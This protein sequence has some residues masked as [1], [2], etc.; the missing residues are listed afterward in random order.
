[1]IDENSFLKLIKEK[2]G[3]EVS[4]GFRKDVDHFI[5]GKDNKIW[6]FIQKGTNEDYYICTL[7]GTEKKD[8]HYTRKK[9]VLSCEAAPSGKTMEKILSEIAIGQKEIEESG[10]KPASVEVGGHRCSHYSFAFGERAYKIADEF[11][12]TIEY[13]NLNDEEGGFRLRNIFTGADVT[14]PAE[15]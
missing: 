4:L 3:F 8:V 11:G 13:S 5:G 7:N 1:M 6:Y 2:N 14:V 15:E 12:I 9:E 10:R